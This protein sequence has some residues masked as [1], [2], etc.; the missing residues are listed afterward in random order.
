ML[1]VYVQSLYD[2]YIIKIQLW[3][4]D[5]LHKYLHENMKGLISNYLSATFSPSRA[6][7][8]RRAELCQRWFHLT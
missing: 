1:R 6:P 4:C 8:K 5:K 7:G 2:I 3:I